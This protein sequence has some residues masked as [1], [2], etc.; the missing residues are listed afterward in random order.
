MTGTLVRGL[1]ALA[2]VGASVAGCGRH[3]N[4]AVQVDNELGATR[5]TARVID[6]ENGA[7]LRATLTFCG[8]GSATAGA[9]GSVNLDV[10][11]LVFNTGDTVGFRVDA[12]GHASV[13]GRATLGI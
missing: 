6:A 1:A 10:F 5:I 8:L 12:P 11:G 13:S 7:P 4:F 2:I 9:D 3:E